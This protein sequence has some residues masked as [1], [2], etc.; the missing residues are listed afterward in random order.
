MKSKLDQLNTEQLNIKSLHIDE[1]STVDMLKLIN[2][3]DKG[4]ANAVEASIPQIELLV[5]QIHERMLQGGRIFYIGAGTSGRLGVLD[6]SECPPTYGVD[7][8]LFQG[9]I[10]GGASA[11][12]KAIEGAEDSKDLAK[13]DLKKVNLTSV[14]TVIG[15]AASGRTPYVIGGLEYAKEMNALTGAISCVENALISEYAEV[16]IEAVTGAEVIMGSTRMKAG[17]A[18][19]L[20][21]NMISTSL[22]IKYGK[23]Y[24]NLM[25]DVQPTNEKLVTRAH[26]IIMLASECTPEE[27]AY[28][29]DQSNKNVKLAICMALTQKDKESCETFLNQT[30]G[31]VAKTINSLKTNHSC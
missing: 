2:E 15:L 30:N 12:L 29:L 16:A 1:M 11:L 19:K 27:A 10:A 20:I 17:T 21:L 22:M 25:V 24:G 14:D 6:A 31:N 18:Q 7:T 3:E 4:V 23:V 13:T 26:R 9:M 8:S 5:N 28:Y